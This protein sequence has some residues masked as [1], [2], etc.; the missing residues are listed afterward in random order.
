[1]TSR[2]VVL[3]S[4]HGSNLQAILHGCREGTIDA[5]V[6]AVVSDRS[7]AFALERARCASV[8]AIVLSH[9]GGEDR[10]AY[11]ARLADEVARHAPDWVVLAGWMRIL[12]S[13]FLDR[14]PSRVVNLHP[15]LPGEF[16]GTHAI[17]RAF[18]A[19]RHGGPARTG[20]MVH[21]VPDEGIDDGPVL[22]TVEVPITPHDTVDT[23][24][25]RV[26]LAEHQLLVTTLARLCSTPAPLAPLAQ[27]NA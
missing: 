22:A 26:H 2:L 15:A 5:T 16:P 12:S 13:A 27:E 24:T 19:H 1:M 21:V 25:D 14:F 9:D 17:E 18:D 10:R 4:G 6:A 3:A 20:V 8:A 23:L 7:E 11:D